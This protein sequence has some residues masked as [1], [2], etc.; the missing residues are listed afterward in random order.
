MKKPKAR[1]ATSAYKAPNHQY[2]KE[3]NEEVWAMI[4]NNTLLEASIYST[5]ST[6][7][8]ESTLMKDEQHFY[9]VDEFSNYAITSLGRLFS[10]R[11]HKYLRITDRVSYLQAYLY[12]PKRQYVRIDRLMDIAQFEYNYED[13]KFTLQQHNLLNQ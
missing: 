1:K 4:D 8:F 7:D 6:M 11:G 12:H 13:I 9:L 2:L 3:S 5:P 10:L